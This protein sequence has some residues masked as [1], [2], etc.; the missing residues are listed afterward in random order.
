MLFIAL[1]RTSSGS[2]S[3]RPQPF[4]FGS[5]PAYR[6][7]AKPAL[8][9]LFYRPAQLGVIQHL[10]TDLAEFHAERFR[11]SFRADFLTKVLHIPA[12]GPQTRAQA[13]KLIEV[14]KNRV[15]QETEKY[16]RQQ[17]QPA[18]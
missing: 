5:A 8:E 3:D 16:V 13:N 6:L 17:R 11:A 9:I 2:P 10:S 14:L 7:P 12:L 4:A 15:K 1:G 18:A